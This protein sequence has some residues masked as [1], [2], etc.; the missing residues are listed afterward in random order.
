MVASQE[1]YS[2]AATSNQFAAAE[3]NDE[4]PPKVITNLDVA[5]VKTTVVIALKQ[6]HVDLINVRLLYR[7]KVRS[8]PR[9]HHIASVSYIGHLSCNGHKS[10]I[11][12][13]GDPACNPTKVSPL[14]HITTIV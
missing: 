13:H 3:A 2:E 9:F 1:F 6:G 5:D 7:F 14:F 10:R 11:S 4:D 12:S 8:T